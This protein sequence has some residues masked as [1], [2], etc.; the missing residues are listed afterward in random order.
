M[1]TKPTKIHENLPAINA[2]GLNHILSQCKPNDP[3]SQEIMKQNTARLV[4]C[5][6]VDK[7]GLGT[8]QP[9]T[10]TAETTTTPSPKEFETSDKLEEE[11]K[12]QSSGEP[13]R[14][15]NIDLSRVQTAHQ[16]YWSA[17]GGSTKDFF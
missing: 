2:A 10:P 6:L 12:T 8:P 15:R 13:G 1:L 3:N 4:E 9:Q 11:R 16:R 17:M 5:G 14:E 7:L